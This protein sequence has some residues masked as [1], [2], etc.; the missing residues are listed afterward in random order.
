MDSYP[1][2]KSL[3]DRELNR[4]KDL[5]SS[6]NLPLT[7]LSIIVAANSYLIK[8][9]DWSL[10]SISITMQKCLTFSIAAGLGIS[11]GYL[12]KSYNNFFKGFA[13]RNL[14]YTTEVRN[15]ENQIKKFNQQVDEENH[16]D[17]KNSIIE[18]LTVLTDN[19]IKFN[20]R[21]SRDLYYAKTFLIICLVLTLINFLNFSIK[22]I[23]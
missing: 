23:I 4:R 5:D 3:Y 13:Y 21:R 22:Y 14:G 9:S 16:I 19:H 11:I 18:K 10:C 7:L 1:F 12:T 20:D 17:F 2:Y 8:E 6:I 15:Y